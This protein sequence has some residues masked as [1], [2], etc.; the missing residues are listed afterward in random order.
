MVDS[1]IFENFIFNTILNVYNIWTT[2]IMFINYNKLLVSLKI[3][4]IK[5]KMKRKLKNL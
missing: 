2:F 5:F 4:A 3:I 1:F